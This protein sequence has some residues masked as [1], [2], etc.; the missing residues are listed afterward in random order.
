MVIPKTGIEYNKQHIKNL[1]S[2]IGF[3]LKWLLTSP[4]EKQITHLISV[5]LPDPNKLYLNQNIVKLSYIKQYNRT[6]YTFRPISD[7]DFTELSSNVQPF[8]AEPNIF[9]KYV[10]ELE[11]DIRFICPNITGIIDEKLYY[12]IKYND[13]K[14]KLILGQP[15]PEDPNLTVKECNRIL[16]KLKR[17]IKAISYALQEKDHPDLATNP[18]GLLERQSVFL[19]DLLKTKI[20]VT[21]HSKIPSIVTEL[22][23]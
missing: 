6:N 11:T 9:D 5:L 17:S 18:S 20:D 15:I 8:F 10:P 7:V 4:K 23:R 3:L 21:T 19:T 22:V 1:S 14:E 2:H 12:Y 13:S 16:L